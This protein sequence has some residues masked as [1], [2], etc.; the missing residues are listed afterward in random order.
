MTDVIGVLNAGSSSIKYSIF[1]AEQDDLELFLS[2]QIEGLLTAPRFV[3]RDKNGKVVGEHAWEP[4]KKIGHDD[5]IQFLFEFLRKQAGQHQLIGVGHRVAHGGAQFTQPVRID[6]GVVRSLEK[7]I[8]LVPLHQPHNLVPIKTLMSRAPHL[9]QIACFDNS[10]H[11][12]NPEVSRL[13]GLPLEY[14]EAGVRR[15]GFHGLSYEYVASKLPEVDPTA[16]TGRSIVLH[17]GS[18]ASMC[19]LLSG[20]SIACSMGFTGVDGLVMG[21]RS[22]TLDPGVLLYLMD[23]LKMDARAIEKLIYQESGLLGISGISNDMRALLASPEPRAKLAID[24]FVYRIARELGSLV[25]ALGGLDAMVFTAGIG[26]RSPAIRSRICQDAA[27]TGLQL[28]ETLN[29]SGGPRI[30]A[31]GSPIAAW[32]IP[33]NEEL[34]IARHTYEAVRSK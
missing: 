5:G 24:V 21:T 14:A 10:F 27:W 32:V 12:T 15:Y 25:A 34:V 1:L 28:D 13:F 16:A 9:P 11:H 26:E 22:G 20:K 19:G 30:S 2:G 17:L 33:T 6:P 23:Q 18:G 7:L 3:A 8:P 29:E 31:E 4:G